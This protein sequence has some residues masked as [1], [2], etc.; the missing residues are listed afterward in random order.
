MKRQNNAARARE[1]SMDISRTYLKEVQEVDALTREE[2]LE[3]FKR[4]KEKQDLQAYEKIVESHLRLVVR[5]ARGYI[6]RGLCFLDLVQEGNQGLIHAIEKFERERGFRFSTY[7]T[8]WIRQNIERA[9]MNQ[10]RHI[11]LPVH[12]I[13]QLTSF[14][15]ANK[16][17]EH[18]E[19]DG[20]T[21]VEIADHFNVGVGEVQKVMQ[22]KLDTMSLDSSIYDDSDS[23][24]SDAI[25]DPKASNPVDM[26]GDE[27]TAEI[28]KD[29]LSRLDE[30][31]HAVIVFRYGL[32]GEEPKTLEAVGEMLGLTRERVR[33]VQ[34]RALS[35]LR[36]FMNFS[37]VSSVEM[38]MGNG[39]NALLMEE[40][41]KSRRA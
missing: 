2:E 8:W 37:G 12:V 5:V 30:L 10:S 25:A 40:V 6:N 3:L 9:I 15:N 7:G 13:K 22:Y 21:E 1:G 23:K 28:L 4:Y 20:P 27:S 19:G 35:R 16:K 18:F 29:W 41:G 33:Q 38:F 11:R 14:L 39:H 32:S 34:M 24:W 36:R 26:I 31:D 17:I